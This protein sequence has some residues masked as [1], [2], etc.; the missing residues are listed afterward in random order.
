MRNDF[1]VTLGHE[2]RS[3][4][5]TYIV[6]TSYLGLPNTGA[7]NK[8]HCL[9][10]QTTCHAEQLTRVPSTCAGGLAT[11]TQYG[12]GTSKAHPRVLAP[13][14]VSCLHAPRVVRRPQQ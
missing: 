12:V 7:R 5:R 6:C 2:Y 10:P 1:L 3:Q 13:G 4:K 9:A 14:A 8:G 11:A